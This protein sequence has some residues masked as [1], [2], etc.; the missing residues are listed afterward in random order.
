VVHL[1]AAELA[2]LGTDL[3]VPVAGPRTRKV[4]A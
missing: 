2:T 1:N 3:A 4:A